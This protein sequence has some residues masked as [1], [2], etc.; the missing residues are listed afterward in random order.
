MYTHLRLNEQTF[1][2]SI[3]YLFVSFYFFRFFL[4]HFL[5]A[6]VWFFIPRNDGKTKKPTLM[7][8]NRS[9]TALIKTR[10]TCPEN[11]IARDVV[12][13]ATCGGV[14]RLSA[15]AAAAVAYDLRVAV[16]A[17]AATD[18]LANAAAAAHQRPL[19]DV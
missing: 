19:N 7:R 12:W 4:V 2:F 18:F 8:D 16:T 14:N 1:Y 17:A 3:F 10:L 6:S 9:R 15:A 5:E 13:N 11:T